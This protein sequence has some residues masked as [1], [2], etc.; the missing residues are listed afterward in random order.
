MLLKIKAIVLHCQAYNDTTNIV[1]VYTEEFGRMSYLA[2]KSTRR[3]SSLRAALF[4]PLSLVELEA[5]HH[6]NR[7]LQRIKEIRSL[8]PLQDILMQPIKNAVALFLAEV[9]YRSLRETERNTVLFQYLQQSI[10]LLDLCKSGL[11]NFHMVFLLKLTRFLGFYPN[12]EEQ[13]AGWY[14]DL[15]GGS[16]VPSRP[17]HNA[18]LTPEQAQGLVQL[19]RINFE[20]LGAFKFNHKERVELLRQVL[21]YYR[22]HLT[23]FPSIKSLEVMQEL[24]D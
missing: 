15:Q 12:I 22:L 11:A 21:N 3:K 9:L 20:N 10:Q 8:L 24:F 23:E 6:A 19:M 13:K 5:E 7:N 16:F 2:G 1:H 17:F 14:F 18:W 4:Q